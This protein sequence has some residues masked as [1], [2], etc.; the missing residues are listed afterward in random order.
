MTNCSP[1]SEA[2]EQEALFEWASWRESKYPILN[3][4]Y[5][6]P[7]GEKRDIVTG[8]KLKRQGVKAGMPDVHLPV[9]RHGYSSLY[10]EMKKRGGTLTEDQKKKIPQLQF[11]GN[12]CEV[13]YGCEE[14]IKVL[15]EYLK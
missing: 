2:Q 15:E 11:A 10:I 13:C 8:A 14:A 9:A 6:I 7:N 4:M 5:A 3:L 12:K 1:P